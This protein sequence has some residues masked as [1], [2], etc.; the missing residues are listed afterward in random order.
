MF[1]YTTG[2]QIK[3]QLHKKSGD[4]MKVVSPAIKIWRKSQMKKAKI[5]EILIIAILAV[6]IFHDTIVEIM[7]SLL[8]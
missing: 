2:Q 7:V 6:I 1:T 8:G 4:A 5:I 3:S